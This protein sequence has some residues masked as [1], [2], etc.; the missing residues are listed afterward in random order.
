[1]KSKL[2]TAAR[3]V[4]TNCLGIKKNEKVVIV[5]DEICRSIGYTIW[6]AARAVADPV[7]L[8]IVP[9]LM[10]G[11]EPP[12]LVARVLEK[13]DVFIM[14]TS[15][16]L[17]HTQA[18]IKANKRGARG[19]TMPGITTA[20]MERTLN[21]DYR[22]IARFTKKIAGLL[23]KAR[24]VR[25]QTGKGMELHLDI[26]GRKGFP[27]TGLIKQ[28]KGFSN[29][30]AGEAYVA[31]IERA[32]TG[33]IM[34]D[35]SFAPLGYLKKPVILHIEKGHIV[36]LQGNMKLAQVFEKYGNKERVLCEFGIG[37]N[38]RAIITGNV[39]EDEKALGSIH[40]AFGNNLGF[41]GTNNARIHLDGVTS[42]PT[43]WLDDIPL[44]RR[45]KFLI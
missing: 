18:R 15:R 10:H 29:L 6:E 23:D 27:D 8:E 24:S 11:E 4:V 28:A 9:R 7:L 12:A 5:T 34:I 16:S 20:V 37:T 38:T 44:I 42:R 39:L 41:G 30:P 31:P 25:I 43:V 1:L 19:A 33:T 40:V 3:I 32:S 17:S 13:C 2:K 21:A 14:P 35:G 22:K 26:T 45:G 36:K